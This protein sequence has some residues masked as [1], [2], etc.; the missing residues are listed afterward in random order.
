MVVGHDEFPN[1]SIQVGVGG[2]G[3]SAVDKV[4]V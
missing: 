3:D 2:D 4:A 1:P